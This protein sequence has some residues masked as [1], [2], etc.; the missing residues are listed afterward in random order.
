M[1][2]ATPQG[3]WNFRHRYPSAVPSLPLDPAAVSEVVGRRW[4]DDVVPALSE[5]VAIPCLSPSF[6]PDWATHG[7]IHHAATFLANWCRSRPLSGTTVEVLDLPGRTP[8]LLVDAAATPAV[9]G[10]TVLFY[11]HLDKQPPFGKWRSG[12]GPYQPVVEG[13][14]L[15]GR[16]T[17]DDGYA[18][19]AALSAL[20]AVAECG[21]DRPRVLVLIEASEESGSPDLEAHLDALGSRIGR[22]DVVVC[23]D[24]GALTYDRLW[25]TSSLRGLVIATVTVEVLTQGQHSGSVGGIVPS[26]FRILR[27]L[28]SRI[29]DQ[30]NGEILLEAAR[31]PVPVA[32]SAALRATAAALGEDAERMLPTVPGL[33]LAGQ[34]PGDRLVREGWSSSLEVTGLAG[35]PPPA[36]AGNVL[37]PWTAAKLSI[38][39][40][41]TCDADAAGAALVSALTT[42]P[43][44]GAQVGVTMEA[45]GQGWVAPPLPTAVAELL[46]AASLTYFGAPRAAVCE[47]GSIPFLAM[48]GQ[49]FP[50]AAVVATGVLGPGSNA[51]GPNEALHL[52]TA[53]RLTACMAQLVA[54]CASPA[55]SVR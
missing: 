33:V 5:Y 45:T 34:D 6:D 14:L 4:H 22:P 43:P 53:R 38:R 9:A 28:L 29:E 8:A 27:Q 16:G 1:R 11:G 52:P 37:R 2:S 15:F 10:P 46:D 44:A 36:E 54:G 48:L 25:T 49:R 30:D 41:P 12:L 3:T 55:W 42:D 39:L 35:A 50:S 23:L 31:A 26:S 47:G 21:A 13:D 51:H 40:G 18:V 32:A 20:A 7:H 19:F 24:S 17:A